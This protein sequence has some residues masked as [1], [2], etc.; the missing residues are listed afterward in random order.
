M[1]SAGSSSR[2]RL[3]SIPVPSPPVQ[4]FKRLL[5][6]IYCWLFTCL[7]YQT[8]HQFTRDQ[9]RD[10]T[11]NRPTNRQ[12]ISDF[13]NTPVGFST[14]VERSRLVMNLRGRDMSKLMSLIEI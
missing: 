12:H 7:H 10:E 11:T 1:Q 9:Y 2:C 4:N 8:R 6:P 5:F 13:F 3:C 14:F